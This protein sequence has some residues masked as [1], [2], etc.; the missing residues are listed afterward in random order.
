[1][2]TPPG[3]NLRH[4]ALS[5]LAA[6]LACLLTLVSAGPSQAT[7]PVH[8]PKSEAEVRAVWTKYG[9]EPSVQDTLIAKFLKG[10]VLDSDAAQRPIKTVQLQE[11]EF[12]TTVLTYRDGSIAVAR[13][14]D[15]RPKSVGMTPLSVSQCRASSGGTNVSYHDDCLAE[16][17]TLS[18][19]WSMRFNYRVVH[20]TAY[21]GDYWDAQHGGVGEYRDQRIY[22]RTSTSIR[23]TGTVVTPFVTGTRWMDINVSPSGASTKAN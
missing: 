17:W 7:E 13:V 21:I 14:S 4:G 1:M 8:L 3:P 11:G 15:T 19:A 10:H 22:K 6:L 5:F 9:V 12:I 23:W 16:H 2:P 18:I 20:G